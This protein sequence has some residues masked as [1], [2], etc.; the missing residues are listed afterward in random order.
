ME[1][2]ERFPTPNISP[3]ISPTSTPRVSHHQEQN[4][5][6]DEDSEPPP[7]YSNFIPFNQVSF[8]QD[9]NMPGTSESNIWQTR[10]D[11]ERTVGNSNNIETVQVHNNLMESNDTETERISANRR[12]SYGIASSENPVLS[13]NS[14]LH[15]PEEL[16]SVN[17]ES[18]SGSND[19]QSPRT[20]NVRA[21]SG[22]LSIMYHN[23]DPISNY[24]DDEDTVSMSTRVQ[25]TEPQ[26]NGYEPGKRVGSPKLDHSTQTDDVMNRSGHNVW[27]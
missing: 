1:H 11:T 8:D 21:S 25:V 13:T 19:I 18:N 12:N 15:S 24:D 17:E 23:N 14:E 27:L 4:E 2:P 6:D 16:S 10:V 3:H 7:P 26:R 22:S 5:V 20:T 9:I